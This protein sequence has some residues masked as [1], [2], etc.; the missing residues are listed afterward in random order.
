MKKIVLIGDSIRMGYDKYVKEALS[1][2]ADVYYPSE[3]C[4]FAVYTLRFLGD[5]KKNGEWPTDIDLVH[6]NA[7]LWDLAEMDGGGPFTPVEY[8]KVLIGRIAKRIRRLFPTA[9][10]VFATSTSV[11]EEKY[12][13]TFFRKNSVIEEFNKAAIE[14]LRDTDVVINDLYLASVRIPPEYR[15]DMTHFNTPKGTEYMGKR[16]VSVICREL[17]ISPTDIN[18]E[19]FDPEAYTDEN[20]GY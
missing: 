17:G 6:F 2:V 19:S 5:W 3:N 10:I 16:V 12:G 20:I 1:G 13:P 4:K 11:I 8:Y 7:G 9:K 18:L 15:S 14:A